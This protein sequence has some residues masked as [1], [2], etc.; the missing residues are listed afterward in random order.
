MLINIL[1][2]GS[3]HRNAYTLFSPTMQTFKRIEKDPL[4]RGRDDECQVFGKVFS[5]HHGAEETGA[6][7]DELFVPQKMVICQCHDCWR[8]ETSPP[9]ICLYT[10]FPTIMEVDSPFGD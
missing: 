1:L 7:E 3:A 4:L 8:G 2:F 9:A 5:H 10:I 6:L